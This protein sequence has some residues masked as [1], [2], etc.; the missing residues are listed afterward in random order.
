MIERE[1]RA[2]VD[3]DVAVIEGLFDR[4]IRLRC[5]QYQLEDA[6]LAYL[7]AR[8][9][10]GFKQDGQVDEAIHEPAE[11]QVPCPGLYLQGGAGLAATLGRTT[12]ERE[13]AQALADL[14]M[15][16]DERR[17][18]E[19]RRLRE[20]IERNLSGLIGPQMAHMV[21]N[22][23]LRLDPQARTALADSM[24]FLE[25]RLADS[26]SRLEGLTADLD[27]QRRYHRRILLELPLGVCSLSGDWRVV[28]WNLA[29]EVMTRVA[30]ICGSSQ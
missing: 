12:A 29:M 30:A 5:H 2:P 6:L 27:R 23:Q 17:P 8:H 22:Q 7:Q 28:I 16:P 26:H 24:R 3:H 15:D 11:Q 10:R 18:S 19:L 9:L 1:C 13:V 14:S 21:I 4:N 25:E 20:R